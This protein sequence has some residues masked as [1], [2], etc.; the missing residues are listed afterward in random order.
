MTKSPDSFP[1]AAIILAAGLGTR[2]KSH[3]PKVLHPLA[4]KPMI[5]TLLDS[6]D[7]A[8][9]GQTVVVVNDD[10]VA[11]VVAPYPTVRQPK[12]FGTGHAV[13]QAK[14]ALRDFDGDVF[15]LFGADPL[16]TPETLAAMHARRRA[17]DEP[18][19]V[20]LGF[21]PEDPALYGRLV[22]DSEG[23][24]EAIVEARDATPEQLA[25]GLCNS[26]V[27]CIDGT[28][29]FDLLARVGDD[30]VKREHYLTDIVALAR[31][32]GLCCAVIEGDAEE[33]IGVD[34]RADLARA[35]AIMQKRLRAKAMA[36]GATLLDPDTVYFSHDTNLGQDVTVGQNVV[37]GTGVTVGDHVT[38]RPFCH[39]EGAEIAKD[40]IIGPFARLR[41]GTSVAENVRVG[42]FVEVKNAM[43]ET[44]AK[45]NH[46]TYVGDAHVGAGANVGAGTITCNYDGFDKHFTNIGAGAFIGSN[47]ALVAPVEIGDGAIV[48]AGSTIAK[49]VA[50]DALA[51]TRAPQRERAAWAAKFRD[52]KKAEKTKR[53]KG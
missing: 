13:M 21:R 11:S 24:L 6:V 40:A 41:P 29:L 1:A 23:M 52:A 14:D 50:V 17:D 39:I 15:V 32:D 37:F 7:A 4:G 2:M 35:E 9:I 49:D 3:L 26:G 12:Q 16:I 10:V 27:M 8:G 43:L 45:V 20:V 33:L 31:T 25:I 5:K 46:L 44:G 53:N 34:D 48:G 36:K 19:I 30:N 22:S 47:T 51:V 18:A 28:R 42:N 38:I